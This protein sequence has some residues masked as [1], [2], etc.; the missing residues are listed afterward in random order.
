MITRRFIPGTL[1]SQLALRWTLFQR[2]KFTNESQVRNHKAQEIA[3]ESGKSKAE[4]RIH[5]TAKT[6]R[7]LLGCITSKRNAV[8]RSADVSQTW[9]SG[10]QRNTTQP[11]PFPPV[12]LRERREE[13]QRRTL[14][15]MDR[16]RVPSSLREYQPTPI[17]PHG[18]PPAGLQVWLVFSKLRNAEPQ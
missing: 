11:S 14:S 17:Y 2:E 3:K 12:S 15:P 7:S 4:N 13:A 18:T 6:H 9:P 16:Y 8:A 5:N 10:P 1:L